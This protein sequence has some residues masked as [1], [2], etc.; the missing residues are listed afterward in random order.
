MQILLFTGTSP[1]KI[2]DE[3]KVYTARLWRRNPPEIGS[4]VRAQRGRR[5]DTSFATLR[6]LDVFKWD[7][8]Y[9]PTLYYYNV[10]NNIKYLGT[11][12]QKCRDEIGRREGYSD[13][14]DFYKAYKEI[15]EW[16]WDDPTRTHWFIEFE[17]VEALDELHCKKL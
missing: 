10:I 8:N 5:K 13:W 14:D 6:I 16:C 15:N 4:I 2:L 17:I 1:E 7:G 3:L 11:T 12:T 9:N